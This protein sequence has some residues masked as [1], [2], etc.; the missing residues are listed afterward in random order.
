MTYE[1]KCQV[2]SAYHLLG[3]RVIKRAIHFRIVLFQ[4][5]AFGNNQRVC[6]GG[7]KAQPLNEPALARVTR[8]RV[9]QRNVF[10]FKE[11]SINE[12]KT[13]ETCCGT[14]GQVIHHREII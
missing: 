6:Y 7:V 14:G 4:Q 2:K 10:D 12:R 1:L 9:T 11:R 3:Q 13:R 8:Q 5:M